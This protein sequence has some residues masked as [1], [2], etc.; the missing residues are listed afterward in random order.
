MCC[1][2]KYFRLYQCHVFIPLKLK[3][4]EIHSTHHHHIRQ[5]KNSLAARDHLFSN[6]M[7]W[8]KL[9]KNIFSVLCV[10]VFFRAKYDR[11]KWII[12]LRN[13][14][15]ITWT[16]FEITNFFHIFEYLSWPISYLFSHLYIYL[17]AI[18]GLSVVL[19]LYVCL[20]REN[21]FFQNKL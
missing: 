10:C 20:V 4:Y 13:V 3:R 9:L 14:D 17:V 11:S 16:K 6:S 21:F 7:D 2:F 15:C 19:R 5:K 8:I 12:I 1:L 18:Y